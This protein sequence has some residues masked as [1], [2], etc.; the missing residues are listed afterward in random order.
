MRLPISPE[1]SGT[2]GN[3]GMYISNVNISWQNVIPADALPETIIGCQEQILTR[4]TAPEGMVIPCAGE[5][6]SG[7]TF[8]GGQLVD[9]EFQLTT[10][11]RDTTPP[12]L[13]LVSPAQPQVSVAEGSALLLEA[14]AQDAYPVTIGWDLDEDGALDAPNPTSVTIPGLQGITSPCFIVRAVDEAGNVSQI[15]VT[16]N[17]I[18]LPPTIEGWV[19]PTTVHFGGAVQLVATATD[20]GGDPLTARVNWGDGQLEAVVVKPDGSIQTAHTYAGSGAFPVTLILSDDERLTVSDSKNVLIY[21]PVETINR[22]L[23]P[24][25][26]N[27]VNQ[28]ILN[29]GQ[30]DSLVVKLQGAVTALANDRPAAPQKLE[31]YLNEYV[32]VVPNGSLTPCFLMATDEL[33]GLLP[34]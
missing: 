34:P 15:E 7:G 2:L 13:A 23:I 20:P 22:D 19:V 1:I 27:M 30:A 26:L 12:L 6:A 14:V 31:A 3:N 25:T 9:N 11:R 32:A 8:L 33:N 16:V 17:I 5:L 10:V 4:D 24:G 29:Q 18:N 28:G 21:S